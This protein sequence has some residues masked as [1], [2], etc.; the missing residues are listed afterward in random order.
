MEKITV[1]PCDETVY[2]KWMVLSS[3]KGYF[4]SMAHPDNCL[5]VDNIETGSLSL[6]KCDDQ[7]KIEHSDTGF[8]KSLSSDDKCIGFLDS[9]DM[10]NNEIE[11]N[12]KYLY[13]LK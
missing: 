8:F 7:A 9:K 12:L 6:G 3:R 1:K 13:L 2:S 11:M 4:Y 5:R 10:Y